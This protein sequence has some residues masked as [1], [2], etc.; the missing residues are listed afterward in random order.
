MSKLP[1]FP[2]DSGDVPPAIPAIPGQPNGKNSRGARPKSAG[3]PGGDSLK[4]S[5]ELTELQADVETKGYVLLWSNV[6]ND[7][8]AFYRAEEDLHKIPAGFVPLQFAGDRNL[9]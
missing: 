4:P 3:D 5:S 2:L 9:V 1:P 7:S 6:L 8:V